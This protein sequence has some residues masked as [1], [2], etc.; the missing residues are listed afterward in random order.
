M[1]FNAWA[2]HP[3]GRGFAPE[4]HYFADRVRLAQRA[5]SSSAEPT[6]IGDLSIF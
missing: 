2:L 1:L 4:D 6:A 5:G 3:R